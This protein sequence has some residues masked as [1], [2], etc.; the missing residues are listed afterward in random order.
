MRYCACLLVAGY[1]LSGAIALGAEAGPPST[2]KGLDAALT[3]TFADAKIIG[4]QAAIIEKGQVVLLKSYGY[5]DVAKKTRVTDDTVFRAGSISKSF[6]AI[7]IMTAVERKKLSLDSKLADVAPEVRFDNRWEATNPVRLVNLLEHTTGWPDI[8]LHILNINEK[9]WSV[10]RGVQETSPEFTSRWQPGY[11]AVYNNAGPAVAA[12]MLEKATGQSFEDYMNAHVLRPMGMATADFDLPPALAGRIA[13]SY[14]SDGTITPYQ[15]IVLK[16]AGSLNT[17]A[18]ELAQLVRLM[19]GR[20]TVDGHQ[21]LTPAS[22]DRIERSESNLAAPFGFT[23]G[24]GLGNAPFPEKGILFRGHNGEI[25]AFTAVEGYNTRCDCGYVLMSNGGGALDFGTPATAL[26]EHYLTRGMKMAPPPVVTVSDAALQ[27]YAGIYRIITPSNALLRPFTEVLSA[28]LVRASPG[29]LTMTGLGGSYAYLPVS[30]HLFRRFDRELSGMAFVEK[31]G[32]LFRLTAF[33]AG[34][35][36]PWWQA[37][38]AVAT[39]AIVIIGPLIALFLAL[40]WLVLLA[41]RRRTARR[42]LGLRVLALPV[43]S[44]ITLVMTFG[45]AIMQIAGSGTSSIA[46]IASP[47]PYAIAILICSILFPLFA[48]AG[49]WASIRAKRINRVAQI[50]L[51]TFSAALVVASVYAASIGWVGVR[52]WTM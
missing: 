12:V 16:P 43:L 4:A 6:T 13:R 39:A 33:N 23:Q 2:I 52:I 5:A 15:Y 21:I 36:M 27:K 50:Y 7:A 34:V 42:R 49:V 24:Y 25:D 40:A 31:D 37:A 19:L 20:G 35:R 41:M 29:K 3:R 18:R 38:I 47:T 1:F 8:S 46:L 51:V 10:M 11:F 9:N 26:V 30:N 32:D 44:F 22:V 17:T 14:G 45:L 28:S 48:I